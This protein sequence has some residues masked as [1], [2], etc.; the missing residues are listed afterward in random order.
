MFQTVDFDLDETS[1]LTPVANHLAP[2]P[3]QA[4]SATEH[5]LV[6]LFL[7]SVT[8]DSGGLKPRRAG[9]DGAWLRLTEIRPPHL[10]SLDC[11]PC[12]V[13]S[14]ARTPVDGEARWLRRGAFEERAA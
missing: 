3:T 10:S 4:A 5:V 1:W 14:V 11:G 13:P 12:V 2:F 8:H 6:D 9:L 7:E